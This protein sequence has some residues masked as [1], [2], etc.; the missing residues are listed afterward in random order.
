[1]SKG[2]GT[3]RKGG[4]RTP[5]GGFGVDL[6][7]GS[8]S[9]SFPL[10]PQV[11]FPILPG[12]PQRSPSR[13][14]LSSLSSP[15]PSQ[16]V[17][18]P[19]PVLP[20]YLL[21]S[22]SPT[23]S[24]PVPPCPPVLPASP[25][26]TQAPLCSPLHPKT[27]HRPTHSRA[28]VSPVAGADGAA[29]SGVTHLLSGDRPLSGAARPPAPPSALLC[30][31]RQLRAGRPWQPASPGVFYGSSMGSSQQPRCESLEKEREGQSSG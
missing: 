9:S 24:T 4:Q 23:W 3:R 12:S 19:H 21:P 8:L 13:R 5:Q 14:G 27:P 1:M 25:L 11:W 15:R 2:G 28:S 10:P 31:L 29:L 6:W 22:A 17:S 26:Q 30:G 18:T 20:C 16:P 7:G